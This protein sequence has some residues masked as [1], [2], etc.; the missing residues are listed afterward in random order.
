MRLRQ[1]QTL[2]VPN[3]KVSKPSQFETNTRSCGFKWLHIPQKQVVSHESSVLFL[4]GDVIE[5]L[6]R[7]AAHES[8]VLFLVGDVIELLRRIAAHESTVLFLVGDVIELLRRIAAHE[9]TVLFL[10]G[11]VI[12][13]RH[14]DNFAHFVG[15]G[16]KS[17]KLGSAFNLIVKFCFV[18]YVSE[19][20]DVISEIQIGDMTGKVY[21]V[22]APG[23]KL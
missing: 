14:K 3:S 2:H 17:Q 11:D 12:K 9:N 15:I 23:E 5:L 22:S 4:V 8:T 10:V 20:N 19:Q 18:C 6:R 7:I 1:D 16:N 13:L 21:G